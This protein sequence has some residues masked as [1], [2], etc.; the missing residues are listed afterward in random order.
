[1]K[2]RVII[3][4]S[5]ISHWIIQTWIIANL[6]VFIRYDNLP[7]SWKQ[8][9]FVEIFLLFIVEIILNDKIVSLLKLKYHVFP[10]NTLYICIYLLQLQSLPIQETYIFFQC[11]SFNYVTFMNYLD[12]IWAD[13][14]KPTSIHYEIL[15][16]AV[17][18]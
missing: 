11:L 9:E 17:L 4:E 15:W 3:T 8:S 2:L 1:M 14:L 7:Y 5:I 12:F 10:N 16:W 18:R 6:S 13:S